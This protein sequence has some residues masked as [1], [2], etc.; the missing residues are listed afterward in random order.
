RR[1][2]LQLVVRPGFTEPG[3]ERGVLEG[4]ANTIRVVADNIPERVE[5]RLLHLPHAAA[6]V[7]LARLEVEVAAIAVGALVVSAARLRARRLL[8][9]R[10]RCAQVALVRRLV[11]AEPRVAIDPE[12]RTLGIGEHRHAARL[13]SLRK[14]GDHGLERLLQQALVLGLAWLEPATVVV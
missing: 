7:H 4:N 10:E 12:R 8:D 2:A 1:E 14:R 9:P 6:D 11:L 3:H 5:P 13:Q